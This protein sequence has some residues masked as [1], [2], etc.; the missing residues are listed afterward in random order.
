MTRATV[1]NRFSPHL[2]SLDEILSTIWSSLKHAIGTPADPWSLATFGTSTVARSYLRSVVIRD[3]DQ[4]ASTITIHTDARSTKLTQI[5]SNPAI[6]LHLY[7]WNERVQIVAYGQASI[8]HN[9]VVTAQQWSRTTLSSRRAYLA[10]LPPGQLSEQRNVNLPEQFQMR[11]PTQ[12]EVAA[13]EKNFCVITC[14]IE[15][16]DFLCLQSTGNIRARFCKE[17]DTWNSSWLTP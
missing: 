15:E 1:P 12:K 3:V 9:D 14:K 5:R 11:I 7:D 2:H 16:L 6:C 10:P 17:N 13:E 4:A 8:H